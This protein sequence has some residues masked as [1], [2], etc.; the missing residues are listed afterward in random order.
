MTMFR[1]EALAPA[2]N[3][4]RH[5]EWPTPEALTLPNMLT[6]V[7]GG[8]AASSHQ[9]AV[10]A[11]FSRHVQAKNSGQAARERALRC[12][13]SPHHR[14]DLLDRRGASHPHAVAALEVPLEVGQLVG[15]AAGGRAV[16]A[17]PAGERA[18]GERRGGE[19]A[20]SPPPLARA[21]ELLG[22]SL[23]HLQRSDWARTGARAR[24]RIAV[25]RSRRPACTIL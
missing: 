21:R 10:R 17:L 8:G 11:P 19:A 13:P 16:G 9:Q 14:L 7:R 4:S 22:L 18:S 12:S 23:A 5:H 24:S 20:V 3:C 25:D 1:A 15:K 6:C 2:Q